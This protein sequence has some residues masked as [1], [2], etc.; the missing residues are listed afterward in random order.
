[1]GTRLQ[2]GATYLDLRNPHCEEF[3]ALGGMVAD[4][5]HTYVP[6]DQVPYPLWNRLTGDEK[7][8]GRSHPDRPSR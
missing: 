6:K 7:P 2:Q 1:M 4:S 5:G 3:T 8:E